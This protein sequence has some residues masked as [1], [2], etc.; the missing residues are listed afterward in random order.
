MSP[1]DSTVCVIN[2]TYNNLTKKMRRENLYMLGEKTSFCFLIPGLCAASN[3]H[4]KDC[5]PE[6]NHNAQTEPFKFSHINRFLIANVWRIC[7]WKIRHHLKF[8]VPYNR[9]RAWNKW[10][11][12][13]RFLWNPPKGLCMEGRVQG[14]HLLRNEVSHV[15]NTERETQIRFKRN[16]TSWVFVSLSDLGFYIN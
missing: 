9:L 16:Y 6:N 14:W 7:K 5:K 1:E 11:R 15:N 4:K 2:L 10:R 3:K 8:S 13:A 12:W